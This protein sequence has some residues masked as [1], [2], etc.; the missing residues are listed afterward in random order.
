MMFFSSF[1]ST[2][3]SLSHTHSLSRISYNTNTVQGS[4]RYSCTDSLIAI[5]HNVQRKQMCVVLVELA[6]FPW[7]SFVVRRK[8]E[9]SFL[10][11]R[12]WR[13]DDGSIVTMTA[14]CAE[15]SWRTIRKKK[16]LKNECE[17]IRG[18]GNGLTV[19]PFASLSGTCRAAGTAMDNTHPIYRI[20]RIA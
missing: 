11:A 16:R 17:L 20:L 5:R 4:C 9:F 3:L 7:F 8:N 19:S 6:G 14:T 12:L 2:S 10:R 13:D 1:L 18:N 15:K